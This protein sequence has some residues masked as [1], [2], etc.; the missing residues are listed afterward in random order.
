VYTEA[1]SVCSL[2]SFPEWASATALRKF[3]TLRRWVPA[4]NTRRSRRTVAASS[5]HAAMV[6]PHGFSL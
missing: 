4:W 2:P 3:G 6:M 1:C 5:W